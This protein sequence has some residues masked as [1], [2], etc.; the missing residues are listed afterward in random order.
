MSQRGGSV[1]ST[2]LV[3]PG[4]GGFIE[5]GSAD[6]VVGLEPL[7]VLRARDR[8]YGETVVIVSV[9]RIVP[10][11][12]AQKGVG[13]PP[14]DDILAGV[15]A[16]AKHVIAI[17]GPALIQKL[18][19]PRVLNI[20]LLGVLAGLDVLPFGEETLWAAIEQRSPGRWLEPN[21]RA[22]ALGREAA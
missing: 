8:M 3:G 11:T 1:E 20:V 2:V 6:V 12:L 21:Q 22:F 13:Y 19:A 10:P 15:R 17:D 16:V 9:G 5:S 14:V 7:E 4:H 18:G